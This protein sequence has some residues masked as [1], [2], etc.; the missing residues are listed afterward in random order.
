[1]CPG[2]YVVAAA[3]EAAGVVT[4]GMSLSAR[5]GA[6][7]NSA[8]LVNVNPDDLPGEDVLEG[9]RLQRKLER[10][11][12][13]AGEGGYVAPAQLLGDFLQGVGSSGA[14][15]VE[16]TYPRGVLWGDVSR[17][18][19]EHVTLTL[20]EA[21][22]LMGRQIRGFDTKDAVLTGVESRSSS[23]VRVT[24]D[25]SCQSVSCRGLW[26][27]GE[28]AGYAGGIMSAAADGLKVA[29]N[30]IANVRGDKR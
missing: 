10:A 13:E 29:Q 26:P 2:G 30:L 6:N 22:P 24:R 27:A 8:L 7:A 20:Q 5:G 17:C 4:N 14:G 12:F 1:M 19:P 18:L 21:I 11:A 16:P 23:P 3:S 9:I 15:S 28:G 25:A